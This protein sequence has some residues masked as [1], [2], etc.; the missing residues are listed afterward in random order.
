MNNRIGVYVCHCGSN[1]SD[2]ID[3]EKV[4]EEISNHKGVVLAKTMMFACADSSQKEII[5]DIVDNQL[6][7]LV[8]ASCSP[9]LHLF[10]FRSVAERAGLNYNQYVQ[11][12]IREQGSWAHGHMPEKATMKAIRLTKMAIARVKFSQ[13]LHQIEIQSEKA[14]L[15]VGAGV[16]GLRSAL[17]LADMGFQVFLVE[18]KHTVGGHIVDWDHLFM[19]VRSGKEIIEE[20]RRKVT[21]HERIRLFTNS[22]IINKTGSIGNF[23]VM[24]KKETVQKDNGQDIKEE[25]ETYKI[26][27]LPNAITDLFE[28]TN[29]TINKSISTKSYTDFG[30]IRITLNNAEYPVIVQL[31]DEK[32]EVETEKYFTKQEPIDFR[33]LSPKKYYVRVVFDAN[34][35]QKWDAGIFLKHQQPERI[36]YYP[37]LL[38]VRAGWDLIETFTLD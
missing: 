9:K 8:I 37:E 17:E 4:R 28:K 18:K 22:T 25:N 24:I 7:G 31:T 23:D 30:N 14:V 29:D 11:V 13:P 27:L 26:L 1:I 38:D 5:N 2:T 6:D 19:N 3:V 36:S 34:E 16:S 33:F 20:L 21:C 15:V 12:N 10:T 32:G 35:N